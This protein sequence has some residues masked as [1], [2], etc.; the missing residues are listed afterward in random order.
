MDGTARFGLADGADLL[1]L[2]AA[3]LW[4]R[5]L[6]LGGSLEAGD[7][8]DLVAEHAPGAPLQADL[9]AQAMNEA[10]VDLGMPTFPVGYQR[11]AVVQEHPAA[12]RAG[13]A[14][15]ARRR[16]AA[17]ARASRLHAESTA[18]VRTSA[19]RRY[20]RTASA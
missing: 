15:L 20:A 14:G 12:R 9:A 17:M 16:S 19:R 13:S 18:L 1:G 4:I 6:A 5:Y 7:F 10:F 3:D 8:A 2:A 11:A